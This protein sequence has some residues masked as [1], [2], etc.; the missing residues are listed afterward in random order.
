M[1]NNE[2][3]EAF[4]SMVVARLAEEA[5]AF[6][7]SLDEAAQVCREMLSFGDVKVSMGAAIAA[8]KVSSVMSPLEK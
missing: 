5:I 7:Y 2:F 3:N 6:G 8:R 1:N 4:I